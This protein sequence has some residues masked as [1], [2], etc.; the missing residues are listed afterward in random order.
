MTPQ[1]L[2][3]ISCSCVVPKE[4]RTKTNSKENPKQNSFKFVLGRVSLPRCFRRISVCGCIAVGGG[5]QLGLMHPFPFCT[6][7][8][9]WAT[10]P[11]GAREFYLWAPNFH[12]VLV[13]CIGCP[14]YILFT[15]HS[16]LFVIIMSK[17]YS[18][19]RCKGVQ[20]APKKLAAARTSKT[21][22]NS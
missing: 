5:R 12:T 10:V 22:T 20:D 1:A 2:F 15:P 14:R 21:G 6:L 8:C 3:V 17:S 16:L 19:R 13:I 7:N 9:R 18:I 4:T 11:I